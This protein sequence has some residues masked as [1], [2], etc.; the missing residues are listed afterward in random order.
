MRP[1]AS[2]LVGLVAAAAIVVIGLKVNAALH[3]PHP[4]PRVVVH[5]RTTVL[6]TPVLTP[7]QARRARRAAAGR[8]PD[9]APPPKGQ[10]RVAR[11]TVAVGPRDR[12]VPV[13]THRDPRRKTA[14][15][16]AQQRPPQPA[17]PGQNPPPAPQPS[18]PPVCVAAPVPVTVTTPLAGINC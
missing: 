12:R 10:T 3:S 15:R 8:A 6:Q 16:P 7:L 17:Q 11:E 5:D 18:K 13:K 14:R 1:I 4:K 9:S 2:V